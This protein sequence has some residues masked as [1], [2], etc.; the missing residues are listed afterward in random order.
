[1]HGRAHVGG[2]LGL[3]LVYSTLERGLV[4]AAPSERGSRDDAMTRD[5]R[6]QGH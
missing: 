4:F 3:E 1:M 2:Q 6:R 5:Y